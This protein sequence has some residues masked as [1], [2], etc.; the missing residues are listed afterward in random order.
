MKIVT[1]NNTT[2]V[3]CDNPIAKIDKMCS[4]FL[5]GTIDDGKS[6]NW[7]KE[8]IEGLSK[9]D[10]PYVTIYNPRRDDWNPNA[11]QEDIVAQIEW[12]QDKLK[13]ATYIFMLLEDTSKSPIS[14][15]ELG[16]FKDS[17]KLMVF[18]SPKFYRWVN[19][20]VFCYDF[21]IP[22]NQDTKPKAVVDS[23]IEEI[24]YKEEDKQEAKKETPLFFLSFENFNF[25]ESKLFNKHKNDNT[26]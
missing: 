14:L 4:I 19:V 9:Y 23:I 16:E 21:M 13:R 8:V 20:F 26:D 22:L 17:K 2:E 1:P 6:K 7:Q 12:E 24:S 18:C 15:L 25:K 10:L 11:A 5:A 3:T